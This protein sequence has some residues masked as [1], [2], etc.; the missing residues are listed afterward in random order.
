MLLDLLPLSLP[1]QTHMQQPG[2]S[3]SDVITTCLWE[4]GK[5]QHH[6]MHFSGKVG[7]LLMSTCEG[8]YKIKHCPCN[9]ATLA[10]TRALS[11]SLSVM[12]IN[13]RSHWTSVKTSSVAMP[14]K[15]NSHSCD[16][17]NTNSRVNKTFSLPISRNIGDHLTSSL[18]AALGTG[19][20]ISFSNLPGQRKLDSIFSSWLVVAMTT[21]CWVGGS[22]WRLSMRD[23]SLAR[24]FA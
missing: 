13:E 18:S 23:A 15:L 21:T 12:M 22:R 4:C 10:T 2:T 14:I 11:N 1:S 6:A 8:H 16:H 20:S 24:A 5:Q 3:S 19:I 17:L 9:C 7:E